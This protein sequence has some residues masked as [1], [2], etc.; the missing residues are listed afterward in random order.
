MGRRQ[1]LIDIPNYRIKIIH[2]KAGCRLSRQ[3]HRHK[4][5]TWI[6]GFDGSSG[7]ITFRHIAPATVHRLEAPSDKDLWVLEV[8]HGSDEDIVRLED[9]YGRA[10]R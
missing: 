7:D 10:D 8:A 6:F 9:D 1:I 5:E 3:L 4:E 2:V